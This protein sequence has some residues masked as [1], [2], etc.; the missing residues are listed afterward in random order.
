[1]NGGSYS[2]F[3]LAAGQSK[4]ITLSSLKL[5]GTGNHNLRLYVDVFNVIT[6]GDETN[7]AYGPLTFSIS[8]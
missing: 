5:N 2:Y 7:N 6:E 1:Y 3:T 4:T 8:Q